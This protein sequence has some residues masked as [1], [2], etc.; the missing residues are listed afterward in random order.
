MKK[1]FTFLLVSSFFFFSFPQSN[2]II[3]NQ[4]QPASF[5]NF[6]EAASQ[7][8]FTDAMG[9]YCF[10]DQNGERQVMSAPEN[11]STIIFPGY[12]IGISGTSFEG[13]ILCNMDSDGDLEVVYNIGYTIQAWNYDGTPV[14]GWP[15]SVSYPLIGAPAYGDIDGDG[16]AEIVVAYSTE[17][18]DL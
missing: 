7:V 17:A 1:L 9:Y 2:K 4:T 8:V 16:Q 5:I 3:F 6:S 10:V 12:P 15:K 11:F 18:A 13:G 14:S